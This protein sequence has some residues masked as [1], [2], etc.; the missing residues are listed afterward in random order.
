[1]RI[2]ALLTGKKNST[3]K[4]KNEIKLVGDYIFNYPAKQAKKVKDINFFYTSSDSKVILN[5]TKKIVIIN[6]KT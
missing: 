2:T 6:I 5:Q 3:L 1:M 4:N